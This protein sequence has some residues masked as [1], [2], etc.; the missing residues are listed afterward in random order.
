MFTVFELV[1][2]LFFAHVLGVRL[3]CI[4][5]RRGAPPRPTTTS[6]PT[7]SNFRPNPLQ[8][9]PLFNIPTHPNT[10]SNTSNNSKSLQYYPIPSASV[11]QIHLSIS[12]LSIQTT[13]RDHVMVQDIVFGLV[14]AQSADQAKLTVARH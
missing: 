4:S 9:P 3:D 10:N 1:M 8:H 13:C 6:T 5:Q 14:R 11:M 12:I 7:R 2:R